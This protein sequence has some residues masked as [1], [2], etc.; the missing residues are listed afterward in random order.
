M[1]KNK[2]VVRLTKKEDIETLNKI[3][4]KL[5]NR[6]RTANQTIWEWFHNNNTNNLSW[7]ILMNQKIIGHHGYIKVPMHLNKKKVM[8]LR[9]ENS[10]LLP[11]YRKKI[12]YF[13]IESK[14]F[15]T[16]KKKYTFIFTSAAKGTPM[17]LRR[18]LGYESFG[19]WKFY[20]QKFTSANI[21][22]KVK[23]I[24]FKKNIVKTLKKKS[25]I[26]DKN[27]KYKNFQLN[28]AIKELCSYAKRNLKANFIEV[29]PSPS[30][31]KWRFKDNP[32]IH[33]NY[34]IFT[35]EKGDKYII[36]WYEKINSFFIYDVIIEYLS[37]PK[38]NKINKVLNDIS[39]K[40]NAEKKCRLIYRHLLNTNDNIIKTE[41]KESTS[42]LIVFNSDKNISDSSYFFDSCVRQ[43]IIS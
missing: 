8:A 33:Y 22:L 16:I 32:Y 1:N 26:F 30:Y 4:F 9:T 14:I 40:F 20:K 38:D 21:L 11:E 24:F 3:Y 36:I 42:H 25:F 34:G 19:C 17:V 5:T 12:S 15:N 23:N 13:S 37:F 39:K 35:D 2:I 31:F 18:R 27:K 28:P 7:V 6:K 43:G 29:Y 10:M 41:I